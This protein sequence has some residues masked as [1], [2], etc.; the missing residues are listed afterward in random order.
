LSCRTQC[1]NSQRQRVLRNSRD[2]REVPFAHLLLPA[3]EIEQHN[4]HDAL[5]GKIGHGRIVKREMAVLTDAQAAKVNWLLPQQRRVPFAFVDWLG[6][7]SF[8]VVKY[9]WLDAAF[10]PLV[11]V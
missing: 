6:R 3:S 4:L 7:V 8:K 5:V 10:H 11:H 9:F 1:W 2:I